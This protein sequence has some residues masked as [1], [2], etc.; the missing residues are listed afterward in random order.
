MHK[1]TARL[2]VH[3]SIP[4][5]PHPSTRRQCK[6]GNTRRQCKQGSARRQCKQGSESYNAV[7]IKLASMQSNMVLGSNR[8]GPN[9]TAEFDLH[10]DCS[11]GIAGH[12]CLRV[13]AYLI[14]TCTRGALQQMS[15]PGR[16]LL[17]VTF[18][19]GYD[20]NIEHDC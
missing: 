11:A 2:N 8:D 16:V 6:Q 4:H 20:I 12:F 17:K 19:V 10:A 13:H 14:H 7:M 9:P 1:S 3:T 5:V 18:W 15:Y